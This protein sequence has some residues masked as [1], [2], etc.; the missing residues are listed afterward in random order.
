MSTSA[1]I[2]FINLRS[3]NF[4]VG[5]YYVLS[6]FNSLTTLNGIENNISYFGKLFNIAYYCL[7]LSIVIEYS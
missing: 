1:V 5:D 6:E 2:D 3:N 7:V 4:A